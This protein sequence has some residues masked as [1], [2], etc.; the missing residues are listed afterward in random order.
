MH[1]GLSTKFTCAASRLRCINDLKSSR[2][3]G[4]LS[5]FHPRNASFTRRPRIRMAD[6]MRRARDRACPCARQ[7]RPRFAAPMKPQC[8]GSGVLPRVAH[9]HRPGFRP[10]SSAGVKAR[11][12]ARAIVIQSA[13][14]G[15]S[16][17]DRGTPRTCRQCAPPREQ[18]DRKRAA[19]HQKIFVH[20]RTKCVE[21]LAFCPPKSTPRQ[22]LATLR[23]RIK[24]EK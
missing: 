16:R 10:N 13:L 4:S 20:S 17:L 7:R 11:Y 22:L 14:N 2:Q 12:S 6:A 1:Q 9:R 5:E 23:R 18:R 24:C 15:R 21:L 8:R 3:A 19:G